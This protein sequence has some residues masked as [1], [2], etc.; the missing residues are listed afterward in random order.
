MFELLV[1]SHLLLR[2]RRVEV[3]KKVEKIPETNR[4]SGPAVARLRLLHPRFVPGKSGSSAVMNLA[5]SDR[6]D[7][8]RRYSCSAPT[9]SAGA[10][11]TMLLVPDAL[12]MAGG[13]RQAI[14]ELRDGSIDIRR[15]VP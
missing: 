9:L 4:F 12:N 15:A 13:V 11:T 5:D 1:I 10:L 8:S 3:P 7:R 14:A 2:E 6:R